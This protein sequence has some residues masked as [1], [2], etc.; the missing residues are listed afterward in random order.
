MQ[1]R[2]LVTLLSAVGCGRGIQDAYDLL[3]AEGSQLPSFDL[4]EADGARLTTAALGGQPTVLALWSS[5]C[6]ASRKALGA[7]VALQAEYRSRGARVMVIADD[8]MPGEVMRVLDSAGARLRVGLA[9]GRITSIFG[10]RH[11]W[12]WQSVALPSFL[13]VDS[14]GVIRHRIVGV[15]ADSA[16]RL[17]RVRTVLDGMLGPPGRTSAPPAT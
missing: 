6:G 2:L 1:A 5:T 16:Q 9:S 4:P 7:M 11:R 13:V 12:P 8:A 3:P 17:D 14:A 10:R 15:E